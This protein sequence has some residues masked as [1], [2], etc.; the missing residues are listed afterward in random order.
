MRPLQEEQTEGGVASGSNV[1]RSAMANDV[2]RLPGLCRRLKRRRVTVLCN[3]EKFCW[4]GRSLK[5]RTGQEVYRRCVDRVK[6]P[7]WTCPRAVDSLSREQRPCFHLVSVISAEKTGQFVF[8]PPFYVL[9]FFTD[10]QNGGGS[11][12]SAA[13]SWFSGITME[14]GSEQ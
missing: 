12:V 11:W 9:F 8:K 13:L 5:N 14:T 3:L 10:L 6:D 7:C 1:V 2:T 4:W